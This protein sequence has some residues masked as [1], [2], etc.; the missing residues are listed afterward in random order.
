MAEDNFMENFLRGLQAGEQIKYRKATLAQNLQEMDLARQR[1]LHQAKELDLTRKEKES[2]FQKW[3]AKQ[4]T[5]FSE[6]A[7]RISVASPT[8]EGSATIDFPGLAAMR[9]RAAQGEG[10]KS[11]LEAQGRQRGSALPIPPT[12]QGSPH[13]AE[14]AGMPGYAAQETL[15][16]GIT[17]K[18]QDATQA[19]TSLGYA[20]L[21]ETRAEH[22][23][24][25]ERFEKSYGL[26]S[27]GAA[28]DAQGNLVR[29]DKTTGQSLGPVV[30]PITGAPARTAPIPPS[31]W[32]L[33]QGHAKAAAIVNNM[34]EM[35]IDYWKDPLDYVKRTTIEGLAEGQVTLLRKTL[36]ESG[37]FTDRDADRLGKLI[38]P[39]LNVGILFGQKAGLAIIDQFEKNLQVMREGAVRDFRMQTG[40]DP[41][42]LM[43]R[44]QM[45]LFGSEALASS[46]PQPTAKGGKAEKNV[47]TSPDGIRLEV[48]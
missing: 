8:G 31:A 32:K 2:E 48:K 42:P 16:G 9:Q 47:F 5:D 21:A 24:V 20:N 17:L 44:E 12:L 6:E 23:R 25:Q 22:G 41:L 40:V 13:V 14:L 19:N 4:I 27:I 36:D 1:L 39:R 33:V 18:G 3:Q 35:A 38:K 28:S 43:D 30:D 45:L 10:L 46:Q 26:R 11:M 29:Y 37:A 34:K 15:S 7:Q